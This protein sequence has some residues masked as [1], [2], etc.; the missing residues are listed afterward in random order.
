MKAETSALFCLISAHRRPW[1]PGIMASRHLNV[2][3][4]WVDLSLKG[5]P[6]NM[7]ISGSALYR[8]MTALL[9]IATTAG[10]ACRSNKPVVATQTSQPVTLAA[11]DQPVSS[12]VSKT[13]PPSAAAVTPGPDPSPEAADHFV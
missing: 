7:K 8:G 3:V 9:L 11:K 12:P 2:R 5:P 4:C 13:Q 10:L 1:T 6:D